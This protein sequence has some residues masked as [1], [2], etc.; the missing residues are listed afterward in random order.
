MSSGAAALAAELVRIPSVLGDEE[1]VAR[2][3]VA[4]MGDLGYDLAEI[5]ATGNAIGIIAGT[6]AGPTLL[7]DAHLDTVDVVP[8]DGWSRSPF[9]G[10]IEGGRLWGRGAS[11]MKGSMAAMIRGLAG[12]DR[13]QLAGRV[14]VSGSVNE[15]LIEGAALRSVMERYPPDLVVIGEATGLDLA[16]AGR[17]RAE[18]AITTRGVPAHASSPR[19]GVNAVTRM[20]DVAREIEALPLPEDDFVGAALFCLTA[21]I[22][23]PYPAHSV[24]PSACHAT[25]ERR[26]LPDETREAL[27][28]ELRDACRRAGAPDTEIVLAETDVTTWTGVV[29]REP[30][31]YPAWRLDPDDRWVAGARAALRSSGLEPR[32]VAYQFCTNA[33]WSAGVAGVPT[34]GFGPGQE[35]QAHVIDEWVSVDEV[36]RAAT[37]YR[38]I[39]QTLLSA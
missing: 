8:R 33:A 35:A 39:A 36:E 9:S 20:F 11:D 21:L 22:S 5:D 24:I 32:L 38:A 3:V 1:R 7:F 16:I 30:K 12:L 15:E 29:W 14:V 28:A 2:R 19:A 26:L 13:S 4:E 10:E 6:A 17:G 27:F 18:L 23:D 31:W 25:W 34:L 37:G